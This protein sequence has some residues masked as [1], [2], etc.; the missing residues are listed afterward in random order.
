M[1]ITIDSSLES[2][3]YNG[4]EVK[5]LIY[6]GHEIWN[7]QIGPTPTYDLL[8]I[9]FDYYYEQSGQ[10]SNWEYL[11]TLTSSNTHSYEY[12]NFNFLDISE[13]SA[14][15]ISKNDYSNAALLLFYNTASTSSKTVDY[16]SKIYLN[17]L[18]PSLKSSFSDVVA[19]LWDDVEQWSDSLQSVIFSWYE[20]NLSDFDHKYKNQVRDAWNYIGNFMQDGD[21]ISGYYLSRPDI[22]FYSQKSTNSTIYYIDDHGNIGTNYPLY[23]YFDA[24]QKWYEN[25]VYIVPWI[26]LAKM[27]MNTYYLVDY[28]PSGYINQ[29]F[30]IEAT[31]SGY[32]RLYADAVGYG[33]TPG[34]STIYYSIN[35][36]A[37]I[38]HTVNTS[39]FD[40]NVSVGDKIR[41]CSNS[42][43]WGYYND[44]M[45][46]YDSMRFGGTAKY[47]VYG[48]I[49]SLLSGT[50]SRVWDRTSVLNDKGAFYYMFYN[51]GNGCVVDAENLILPATT[52]MDFAYQRMFYQCIYL[53]KA[54]L[55]LP[56][57]TLTRRCYQQMFYGCNALTT[58]P[59]ILATTLASHCCNSM[60]YNCSS[61]TTAPILYATTLVTSCYFMMFYGCSSLNYIDAYFTSTPGDN[62][63]QWVYGVSQTGTFQMHDGMYWDVT[64]DNGIPIGWTVIDRPVSYN[65]TVNV[66]DSSFGSAT[67]AG[68]YYDNQEAT[69]TATPNEGYRLSYWMKD[70]VTVSV[71]ATYTFIVDSSTAG[72]YTAVFELITYTAVSDLKASSQTSLTYSKLYFDTGITFDPT[73]EQHIEMRCKFIPLGNNGDIYF[74]TKGGNEITSTND[75]ND[76]RLFRYSNKMYCDC[77]SARYSSFTLTT[78]TSY[79]ITMDIDWSN[80][81]FKVVNNSTSA[82]LT[83]TSNITRSS[84]TNRIFVSLYYMKFVGLTIKVN[85]NTVFD[86]IPVLDAQN[87][88]CIYDTVNGAFKYAQGTG[89]AYLSYD[90]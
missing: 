65:I 4:F 58:V 7:K 20:N 83:N 41:W 66:N 57:T 14:A 10:N 21:A 84:I 81:I 61:I 12:M 39:T 88:P 26:T 73:N 64:G 74:G 34:T 18:F 79:D 2:I 40:I 52:L 30:T 43:T 51:N 17:E 13:C 24:S 48:N 47:K 70:G 53:T 8:P 44:N 27:L 31:Q 19:P 32:I 33:D 22:K 35:D 90:T 42:G 78:N 82:T 49:M 15:E 85:D 9:S 29:Y 59:S 11:S 6:N 36:S 63:Y 75:S 68:I 60:F 54:P 76:F 23:L 5:K 71:N 37:W 46:R 69:L 28:N 87:T 38:E 77:A 62:T 16:V 89:T 50:T 3:I 25:Q 55:E 67:G 72:S 56:A 86:G 80:R 45:V 1:N